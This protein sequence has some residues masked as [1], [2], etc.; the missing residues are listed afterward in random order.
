MF[1]DKFRK[2]KNSRTPWMTAPA[3][4]DSQLVW[5]TLRETCCSFCSFTDTVPPLQSPLCWTAGDRP[6]L[7]V[8][9]QMLRE[10]WGPQD[11]F[12]VLK[13]VFLERTR[14]PTS[15]LPFWG[16]RGEPCDHHVITFPTALLTLRVRLNPV[17]F[18]REVRS[19]KTK[20]VTCDTFW[21][22][23]Q[24]FEKRQRAVYRHRSRKGARSRV[25]D[26]FNILQTPSSKA[27]YMILWE[28]RGI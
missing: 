5:K 18:L 3:V 14:P 8:S 21:A 26:Q 22:K 12:V 19:S 25:I 16:L 2:W 10:Q 28:L 1:L 4:E 7:T 17:D 6:I 23:I 27:T 13:C 15:C 20:S 9:S 11:Q 24:K